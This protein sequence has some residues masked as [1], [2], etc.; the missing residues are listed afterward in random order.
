MVSRTKAK[1]ARHL[2]LQR[3]DIG[4]EKFDHLAAFGTDHVI[5]V[6]VIVVVLIVSFV[7]TKTHLAS[8][9]RLGQ[10]LQRSVDGR[11]SNGPVNFLD[12]TVKIFARKMVFRT[13]KYLKN[14]IPLTGSAQ[15]RDLDMFLE[16]ALFNLEFI[17]FLAQLS[18]P[19]Y[20]KDTTISILIS[21]RKLLFAACR[22][23]RR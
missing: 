23:A 15:P 6:I 8:Q 10:K 19:A 3:F 4:R 12:E 2:I 16:N 17:F 5:V 14:Q 21:P 22:S 9:P 1:F 13:Q 20:A 11:V 18:F 7:I